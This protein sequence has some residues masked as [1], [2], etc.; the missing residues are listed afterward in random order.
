MCAWWEEVNSVP[1]IS[2]AE[3]SPVRTSLAQVR[4]LALLESARASGV[5]LLVSSR[6][7][8][9]DGWSSKTSLVAPS[10][11]STE[12]RVI[13]KSAAMRAYRFRCRQAMSA[14]RTAAHESSWLPTLTIDGNYN[15]KGMSS[16]S[17]DG[18]RT[19]LLPTLL[20]SAATRGGDKYMRGDLTLKSTLRLLP[21]LTSSNYGS[22]QGGARGTLSPCRPSLDT[23]AR[24]R[25]LPSLCSRDANG[26][27]GKHSKGGSDL[28]GT[29][30]GH[31]NP[32]WCLWF[33]GFPEGY[34]DVE[35]ALVFGPSVTR[36][37]RSKRKS[38]AG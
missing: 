22:N 37:S 29:M 18:L 30:G 35:D 8:F 28:P 24:Q 1:W 38:S 19:A 32:E 6:S 4:A 7:L 11:G 33:M 16:K 5:S 36:S 15:R 9:P 27:R 31:L 25:L 20:S 13:W 3:A 21:T 23:L 14:L 26:P 12:S 2:S 34:L 10:A 17:G